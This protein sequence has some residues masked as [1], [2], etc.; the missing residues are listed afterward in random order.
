MLVGRHVISH[1]T[2]R[3]AGRHFFNFHGNVASIAS[4]DRG[5]MDSMATLFAHNHQYNGMLPTRDAGLLAG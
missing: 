3:N 1:N 4:R 5:P 2:M